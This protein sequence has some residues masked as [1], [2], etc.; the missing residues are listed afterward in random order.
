MSRTPDILTSDGEELVRMRIIERQVWTGRRS[1]T[2]IAQPK[3]YPL[4]TRTPRVRC[5]SLALEPGLVPRTRARA[6]PS[7]APHRGLVP[8]GYRSRYP[9]AWHLHSLLA[10]ACFHSA[11]AKSRQINAKRRASSS[12]RAGRQASRRTL[13]ASTI[14]VAETCGG[15]RP[16]DSVPMGRAW[17]SVSWGV[18]AANASYGGG[19]LR[20]RGDVDERARLRGAHPFVAIS[21]SVICAVLPPSPVPHRVSCDADDLIPRRTPDPCVLLPLSLTLIVAAAIDRARSA[22][23]KHLAHSH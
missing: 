23:I 3:A 19:A 22:V 21:S 2:D 16:A 6:Q 7:T 5:A 9:Q 17:L 14:D 13:P 12:E 20:A 11:R 15:G 18:R 10:T 1:H 8:C 4:S